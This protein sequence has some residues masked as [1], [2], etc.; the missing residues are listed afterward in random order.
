MRLNIPCATILYFMMPHG[1]HHCQEEEVLLCEIT[2]QLYDVKEI[3]KNTGNGNEIPFIELKTA[4][5]T[6]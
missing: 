3:K 4:I 2:G 5:S 6:F 1:C